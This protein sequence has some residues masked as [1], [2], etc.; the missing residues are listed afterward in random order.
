MQAKSHLTL[1][2]PTDEKRA[3]AEGRRPNA[4]LTEAEIEKLVEAAKRNRYGPR[5]AT[6][7]LVAYRHADFRAVRTDLGCD[8]LPGRD[9]SHQP[10]EERSVDH[11]PDQWSR[12]A[13]AAEIAEGARER[14]YHPI[15]SQRLQLARQADRQEAR[16]PFQVHAHMLCEAAGYTLANARKDTRSIQAYLG[17]KDIRH[18][19]RYTELSPT[20]FKNF[21]PD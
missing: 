21:F 7:I 17:H 16:L 6:M 10:Q 9:D 12:A 11:A 18:T 3:V 14:A 4:D 1:V 8:R 13:S 15:R 19:V 5:D 20:R 2:V